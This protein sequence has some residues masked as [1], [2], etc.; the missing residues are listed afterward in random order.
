MNGRR[1]YALETNKYFWKAA[2]DKLSDPGQ[3]D[4]EFTNDG[5]NNTCSCFVESELADVARKRV[6]DE[7]LDGNIEKWAQIACSLDVF[8]RKAI[9]ST[10]FERPAKTF[11]CKNVGEQAERV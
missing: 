9:N 10:H 1:N 11:I 2:K 6:L 3:I 4:F 8:A 7:L 5:R